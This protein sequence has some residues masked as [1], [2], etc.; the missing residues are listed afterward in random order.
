MFNLNVTHRK[1]TSICISFVFSSRPGSL[2][3]DS[4]LGIS[5]QRNSVN[6]PVLCNLKYVLTLLVQQTKV[7]FLE[8]AN[9]I[10]ETYVLLSI[11]SERKRLSWFFKMHYFRTLIIDFLVIFSSC[12]CHNAEKVTR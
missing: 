2:I 4:D 1:V 8:E 12:F 10:K 5:F 3:V 7:C 9:T 6:Y 11:V